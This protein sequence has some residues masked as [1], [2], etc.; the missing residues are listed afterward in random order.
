MSTNTENPEILYNIQEHNRKADIVFWSEN[1]NI[2]FQ[3]DMLFEFFPIESMGYNQKLNAIS[4][5]KS[6]VY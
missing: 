1:P 2:L 5:S 6:Y 4:R 3:K